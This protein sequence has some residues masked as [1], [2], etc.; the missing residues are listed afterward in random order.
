MG[1]SFCKQLKMA[2]AATGSK[3]AYK[4]DLPPKGGYEPFNYSRIPARKMYTA[5]LLFGGFILWE[6]MSPSTIQE[7]RPEKCIQ[8]H[9]FLVDSSYGKF[10]V[11]GSTRED[12]AKSQ[13]GTRKKGQRSLH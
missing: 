10:S 6:D 9:Y 8:L 7:Y 11:I 12:N 2:T 5:P 3:R 1:T 13:H 4:Q